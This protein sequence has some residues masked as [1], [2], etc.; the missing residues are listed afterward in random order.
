MPPRLLAL[1]FLP[2]AFL[3]AEA[4]PSSILQ[5]SNIYRRAT[6]VFLAGDFYKPAEPKLEDLTFKLAPLLVQ[7][8]GSGDRKPEAG[9]SGQGSALGTEQDQFG[10]L[11]VS[12]GVVVIDSSHPTI[13]F[14][15]VTVQIRGNPHT[16]LTYLWFY[17]VEPRGPAD[18]S[19][20]S[21]GI[22]LTLNSRGDPVIWEV[23]GDTS[24]AQLIFVSES[25]ESAAKAEFGQPLPGRRYAVERGLDEAPRIIVPRV[26]DDGPV[27][28][29]PFVYLSAETRC[30]STL[31]CRCMPAQA[32]SLLAT[33]TYDLVPLQT[34]PVGA[35]IPKTNAPNRAAFWPGD[36]QRRDDLEE[37][38]RLPKGF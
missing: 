34:A 5:S 7:Q 15:P 20:P 31:I 13:Y 10:A 18:M 21:Q 26:I 36:S 8:V 2:V 11:N 29:G 16:Q 37:R 12:N 14:E 35:L 3:Q 6:V 33:R 24:G 1:C 4:Q 9:L 27:P 28:M 23:L 19:L 38:L 32:K 17:A 25:I 22:R 30:V